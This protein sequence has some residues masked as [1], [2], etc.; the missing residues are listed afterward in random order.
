[1]KAFRSIALAFFATLTV[2]GAAE[3]KKAEVIHD[4]KIGDPAPNFALPGIDGKTHTLAEYN[5][6]RFLMLAFIS[7]HCPDSHAAERRIKKLVEDPLTRR[8][9]TG[10]G[11]GIGETGSGIR[12]CLA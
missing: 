7:N 1:M 5:K 10:L 4:V 2:L 9:N 11:R 12:D 8:R 3:S 6:A